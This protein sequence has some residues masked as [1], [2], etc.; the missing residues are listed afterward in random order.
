MMTKPDPHL[1][2][3][4]IDAYIATCPRS[5]RWF[6]K[7]T[8]KWEPGRLYITKK[9]M[10]ALCQ[11]I[12]RARAAQAMAELDAEIAREELAERRRQR[13]RKPMGVKSR[14]GAKS[15]GAKVRDRPADIP[16]ERATTEGPQVYVTAWAPSWKERR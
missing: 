16:I 3:K 8:G 14:C 7:A 5:R 2:A 12:R 6:N 13:R 4:M 11:A 10:L 15:R 1:A 9:S